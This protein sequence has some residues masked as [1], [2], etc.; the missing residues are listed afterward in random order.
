MVS[1]N[2]LP[3]NVPQSLS[4]RREQQTCQPCDD[5]LQPPTP[6][7]DLYRRQ[8]EA[9]CNNATLAIFIMDE[10]QQ[11]TYMNP[12]AEKLTGY[13]LTEVRGRPLHDVIHHTRPDGTPYPLEECPIDRAFPQNNQEQGEEIFIH[14]DGHFYPVAYTAS[15][16]RGGNGVV[17]TIIEV[18]DISE[19]KRA[20]A[21]LQRAKERYR[22]FIQHSSE[23][24]W[25]FELEQPVPVDWPEDRLIPAFYH[26]GYLAECN[27][28]MAQM[29]G[30]ASPQE[31][32]G[33]RLG[34]FLVESDPNNLEYLRTFIRSGYRLT[35][36][37][38]YEVDRQGQ[39]KI[40][41]N[42]LVGIV[43]NG[44]LIRAWGTQRDITERKQAEQRLQL[45][46]DVVRN[47]QM[48]IVVWQLENLDDPASFRLL[49]ANP[50]ASNVT[51]IE[52]ERLIGTT[53]G[54][55]FPRLLK[56]ELVERYQQVVRTGEALDL[57]EVPYAQD[58]I[59]AGVYNLKAFALPNRCLGLSFENITARK[60]T[61]SQLQQ[62]QYFNQQ[63]AETV[64]G[65]LFVYDLRE[66]R[67]VYANHQVT[68]LLGYT[69]EQLKA[70]EAD[71]VS[72]LTHPDDLA[73]L[74]A[75]LDS[76]NSA[77]EGAIRAIEYRSRDRHGE[78]RWLYT[79]SLV[80]N[81]TSDGKPRQI[82]GVAIDISARKRTEDA[83]A[84]SEAKLKSFMDANVIGI[85]FGDVHGSIREAND[86]LLR[87]V[88]YTRED[89]YTGKLSWLTITPPEY[90]PLDAE[91]I[92]EAQER[93]ACTPYEKEYIRKDGSRVPI[94][95][96]YSLVGENREESVAFILDLTER[97]QAEAEREQLLVREQA[98]R[99]QA[100]AANRIKDEFLAVLSHELRTPLNP[101]LGWSKLLRTNRLDAAK[102]AHAL[103]TIERNAKLQTQ[104]IEDLLDVSR[105]LRG[106]LN[107]TMAPVQLNSVIT[108]ALETVR[109]AAEAKGI[110]LKFTVGEGNALPA[111]SAVIGDA[112]RLQQVVW[113]LLS[114]A[115][116]FT[117]AGGR[118]E[119]RVERVE[120]D[121][122]DEG[123]EGDRGDEGDEGDRGAGSSSPSLVR[124]GSRAA[125]SSPYARI[126]VTDTG[127]GISPDFLPYV[128]EYFRQA[129]GST[130]RHFGGLGLG[131]AIVRHL[132]ELHGGT[133]AASSQG[134]GLG[135]T[136]VVKL[137]L[138][139][140][141]ENQQAANSD[142]PNSASRMGQPL[143]GVRVLVV[144][145]EADARELVAFLLERVGAVVT[146]V[147]SAMEALQLIPQ[148]QPDILLSDIGMP[149]MNGYSLLQEL[150]SQAGNNRQIPA[151]ALTAYA[152][153]INQQQALKAGF[154]RHLAKPV[155]PDELV[156]AIVAV[157]ERFA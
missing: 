51:G 41:L 54:E 63:I 77:P 94:L 124:R 157:L 59:H 67:V 98:A 138:L 144:D 9:V 147:A 152:G 11:C 74:R 6:D 17:G 69:P 31:L 68:D 114:N 28:V 47:T 83:L 103:E 71:V 1:E 12:A 3:Q 121:R 66:Q 58:G 75:Y 115:V 25:C 156:Q 119:V 57:G 34:E 72:L 7:A 117:P 64:P 40:F 129:D 113:N 134:E 125:S 19:R 43:E 27:Q 26:Y 4:Q 132:V 73:D 32:I 2:N 133:V 122:G 18:Q 128:F 120:G 131:L 146:S 29:Y 50:A 81:R 139:E 20:E 24:I 80:F 45:F 79:Q 140:R 109:L 95:L 136:F 78:W 86:E 44:L 123:D 135:S 23:G 53:M 82:L 154:Q 10:R 46:A 39:P 22:A 48:G 143:Q 91:R 65:I 14:R 88:G 153:E 61:E 85:L 116:K 37:E 118:V 8:L 42:N 130:T 5:L 93:G 108:A 16:I 97:K 92:A 111:S 145:D 96:G 104:L 35:D 62:T 149:E 56:T 112:A 142:A 84:A 30:V 110:E 150:R 107:L 33:A 38:S 102:T 15:P 101:I 141:T 155:E 126:T 100:E 55:S 90:L 36:A 106:K 148:L 21:E 105:I 52:F 13:S 49:I 76:F 151:I 127:K 70:L 87:I 99:E 137:P 89:L 60:Y